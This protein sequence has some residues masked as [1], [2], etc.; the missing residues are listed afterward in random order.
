MRK[1]LLIGHFWPFR[2]GS[3]RMIGLAKY[4]KKFGW[5]PIII[6]GPLDKKPGFD[7]RY[8]EVEYRS[9]LGFKTKEDMGDRF[10]AKVKNR[11][12]TFKSFL[13]FFYKF[14]KE[15]I[16]YP[17]E[18]KYW[19]KPVIKECSK[20]IENEKI[21]AIISVW[22]ITTHLIAKELKDKYKIPWIADFP[23]LWS[24]NHNYNYGLIRKFFDRKLELKT[25]RTADMLGTVSRFVSNQLNGLHK[26]KKVYT[27]TNGFDPEKVNNPL[28]KL[29]KKFT[30]TY[31]GQ[32]YPKKQDS[33]K[34]LKALQDLISN[35]IINP[36]D[37]DVRFYGPK[38]VWLEKAI[39]DY[40]L[41]DIVKQYEPI[42]R[43]DSLNKQRES[44][45]LLLL[46][47]EDKELDAGYP[48]KSFEYLAAQRPILTT[49]G[50]PTN[51]TAYMIKETNA[52]I[53]CQ[54]VEDIKKALKEF[55]LEYKQNGEV[56][57]KGDWNEI[58][59]YSYENKAKEFADILN[60]IIIMSEGEIQKQSF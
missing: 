24:Q 12:L 18:S 25:L 56:R 59:K 32:I 8:L 36:D 39:K 16:A 28:T 19:K 7:V 29:T 30:I 37:V 54:K 1:V 20:I 2:G 46:M 17:D 22:P 50:Y 33:I 9:F 21:D 3:C 45:I 26:T 40:K 27:I 55:Y 47:W 13:K 23:D 10:K 58:Q 51:E 41:S 43:E 11:S 4:L 34:I 49:G 35:G 31:T 14:I 38:R 42:T 44:Q 15:I 57:Y 5:E 53:Y 48:G 60:Q 52:G 6:T